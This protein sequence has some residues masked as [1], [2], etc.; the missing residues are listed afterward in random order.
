MRIAKIVITVLFILIFLVSAEASGVKVY[1]PKIEIA[2]KAG[3]MA[4]KEITVANPT[5]DVQ[6][7][8]VYPD[9]LPD[10]IKAS[11]SSFTLEAGAYKL[12][13]IS[14]TENGGQKSLGSLNTNIS[15]VA[16]PLDATGFQTNA[17]VKIPFSVTVSAN[18]T[19]DRQLQSIYYVALAVV[20][21]IAGKI[22]YRTF[23]QR[24]SAK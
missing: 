21:F 15:V 4:T 5:S 24:K 3:E 10:I 8:K 12:V 1:P 18:N 19:V 9:D 23:R 13:T 22:I 2:V 17:G 6:L 20:L 11:P 14:I 16:K 7:F